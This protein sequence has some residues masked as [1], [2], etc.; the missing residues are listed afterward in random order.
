M[1]C[2][3]C[4]SVNE[5]IHSEENGLLCDETPEA[6]AEALARLMDNEALRIRLGN[7]AKAD[8]ADYAPDKVWTQWE[9]LLKAVVGT[10]THEGRL[11]NLQKQNGDANG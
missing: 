3:S 8:M 10:G 4:P 5:Q 1:G 11:S 6:F 7:T 9:E 2:K